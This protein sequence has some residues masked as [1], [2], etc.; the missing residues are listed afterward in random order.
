MWGGPAAEQLIDVVGADWVFGALQWW[1][2]RWD[3]S[4]V[5]VVFVRGEGVLGGR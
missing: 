4:V 2:H 1:R 3:G 5:P